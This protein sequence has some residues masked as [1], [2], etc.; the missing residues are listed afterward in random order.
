MSIPSASPQQPLIVTLVRQIQ[1]FVPEYLHGQL[2]REAPAVSLAAIRLGWEVLDAEQ[3]Q[4]RFSEAVERAGEFPLMG[5]V[6]FGAVNLLQ[7]QLTPAIREA[8]Q[9]ILN[10]AIAGKFEP[11]RKLLFVI[12][13]RKSDPEAALCRFLLWAGVQLNLLILT[14]RQPQIEASGVLA[15]ME[16]RAEEILKELLDVS[17][18]DEPDCRPLHALVAAVLQEMLITTGSVPLLLDA[19][20]EVQARLADALQA[21]RSL[22]ARDAAILN[23]GRFTDIAGSQQILDRFPQ[24][25]FQSA[26]S[27]DQRRRRIRKKLDTPKPVEGRLVDLLLATGEGTQ[28]T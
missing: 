15:A 7:H 10:H 12:A 11:M 3:R 26:N 9:G 24:H 8:L 4:V 14:W 1:P 6:Y 20:G 25:E 28:S 17:D 16:D 27:I 22:D 23:P 21:T 13:R 19:F 5:R 2:E 18:I